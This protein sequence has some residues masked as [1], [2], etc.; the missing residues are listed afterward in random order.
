MPARTAT[1]RDDVQDGQDTLEAEINALRDSSIGDRS[2]SV[3]H[4]FAGAASIALNHALG[5][6]PT[7]WVQ[8]DMVG[9]G[10]VVDRTAWDENTITFRASGACSFSA[11]VF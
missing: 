11:L 4:T 7:G 1:D 9:A 6:T 5:H 3:S 8:S 10:V 2:N